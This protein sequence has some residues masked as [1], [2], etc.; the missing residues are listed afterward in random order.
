MANRN[1]K[2][3]GCFKNS[4]SIVLQLCQNRISFQ[5]KGSSDVLEFLLNLLLKGYHDY[6]VLSVH[7][8]AL[9]T[10]EKILL[11]FQSDA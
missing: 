3:S 6:I 5:R 10:I 7:K 9:S 8:R 1:G 11:N 2:I 4:T